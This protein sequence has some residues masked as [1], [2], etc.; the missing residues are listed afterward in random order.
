M[1][2]ESKGTNRMEMM[3]KIMGILVVMA[4]LIMALGNITGAMNLSWLVVCSPVLVP[5]V[6]GIAV[7]A[8]VMVAQRHS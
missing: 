3:K 7:Q 4:M 1:A 2:T 8:M 6:I 5:F